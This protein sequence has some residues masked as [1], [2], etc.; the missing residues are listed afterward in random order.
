MSKETF[1][2]LLNKEPMNV[3]VDIGTIEDLYNVAKVYKKG[4]THRKLVVDFGSMSID[5]VD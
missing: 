1:K 5:I 2:L 3:D 4:D